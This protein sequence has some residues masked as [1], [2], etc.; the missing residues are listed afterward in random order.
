MREFADVDLRLS[1][2]IPENSTFIL[3]V[4]VKSELVLSD[5]LIEYLV[6]G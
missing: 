2:L 4:I 1:N 5:A 3:L 6:V